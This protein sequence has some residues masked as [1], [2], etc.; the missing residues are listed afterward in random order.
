MTNAEVR[1]RCGKKGS[2]SQKID[3]SVLRWYGH[4]ERM[5]DERIAKR[6]YESHVQGRRR[7]GRP[8]KCWM[9]GVSELVEKMGMNIQEAKV[10]VQD[11]SRWRSVCRG[12]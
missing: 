3:R 10:C 8:R 4:V 2:V 1:R 9:D 5:D 12:V 11:R 6:V 7:R